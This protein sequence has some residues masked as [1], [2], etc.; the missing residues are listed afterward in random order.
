MA[1]LAVFSEILRVKSYEVD[2]QN[3]WKPHC[4]QQSL[5]E[6]AAVHAGELGF[7]YPQMR[8]RGLAWV[9]SRMR[10][11]F[12]YMPGMGGMVELRTWPKG[13]QQ[14]L[15]F[16]RDFT[17]TATDGRRIAAATSAWVLVDMAKRRILPPSALPGDLPRHGEDAIPDLLEKIILPTGDAGLPELG[18]FS[19]AY[20]A[21]DPVGHANSA[22]YVEWIVDCFP[23]ESY[24]ER[25]LGSLQINF[26]TEVKP[27]EHVSVGAGQVD[28]RWLAQ[29]IILE[30]GTRAF[31]ASFDWKTIF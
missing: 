11:D 28:A 4:V 13:V 6:A 8:E 2:F 3:R 21:V 22:R 16:T 29:G 12:G 31:E 5:Q 26:S 24:A 10:I 14:R 27:G 19:P 30:S 7:G 20:S 1:P 23:F 17:L 18:T 25:S 9:L 15:F